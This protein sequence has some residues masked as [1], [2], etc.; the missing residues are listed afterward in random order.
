MADFVYNETII[1][2]APSEKTCFDP[3]TVVFVFD[4]GISPIAMSL[5]TLL[6]RNKRTR[7][8]DI[9]N[10]EYSLDP[11][12]KE[13]QILIGA[14][15]EV[16]SSMETYLDMVKYLSFKYGL[17]HEYYKN[18]HGIWINM[19]MVRP[20]MGVINH[21]IFASLVG[22]IDPDDYILGNTTYE[23]VCDSLL[24]NQNNPIWNKFKVQDIF[25]VP[26]TVYYDSDNIEH[27]IKRGDG[28]YNL[29][30]VPCKIFEESNRCVKN[31]V[32]NNFGKFTYRLGNYETNIFATGN[33]SDNN[34]HMFDDLVLTFVNSDNTPCLD[35]DNMFIICNGLV[36][37]YKRSEFSENQIFIPNIIKYATYQQTSMKEGKNPDAYLSKTI[38]DAG[39]SIWNFNIPYESRGYSYFFDI[40]IYKW[41]N[42]TVSHHIAPLSVGN[43]L[44]SEPTEPSKSIWL[45]T[46][47][48]FSNAI[49]KNKTV[50]ICNNQIVSKTD[51]DVDPSKSNSIILKNISIEFDILYSE[52][53]AK[54]KKY[55]EIIIGHRVETLPKITDFIKPDKTYTDEEFAELM[56]EYQETI[57]NYYGAEEFNYHFVSS[58]IN[59]VNAQFKNRI[60]NII[61][62]D[63][64]TPVSYDVEVI[65]NRNDIV[66]D[67]PAKDCMRN[68][69]WTPDDILVINGNIHTFENVYADVFKPVRRWYLNNIDGVFE[70]ADGYK[71]QVVRLNKKSSKYMKLNYQMMINGQID[72]YR[73]FTYNPVKDEYIPYNSAVKDFKANYIQID[74]ASEA[75]DPKMTYFIKIGTTYQKVAPSSLNGFD[76]GVTYFRK[77][78]VQDI[79][80]LKK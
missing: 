13:S 44:K 14:D 34:H 46:R 19:G 43:L 36:V 48:N 65:E 51:W 69:H 55:L 75:F 49:D 12:E 11:N 62:F 32:H 57:K 17:K 77:E 29:E 40:K 79:Y 71:L 33:Y 59:V 15:K 30:S 41:E 50:L 53:Y 73:Y 6:S 47:L 16:I 31:N 56:K 42:V 63:T 39:I 38:N 10:F 37:D 60:Y 27:H 66:F 67:K 64:A 1:N 18:L 5:D 3:Q 23:K 22:N 61:Q 54:L 52:L 74:T 24:F 20:Q 80:V 7:T 72:G 68:K 21:G 76:D 70:N 45:T 35:L 9:F 58:A 2:R 28:Q 4:K 8:V 25:D 26:E 78:F